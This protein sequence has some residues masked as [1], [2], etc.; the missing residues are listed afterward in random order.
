MRAFSG[1]VLLSLLRVSALAAAPPP[2]I[3]IVSESIDVRAVNVEAVVVDRKGVPVRGLQASDLR[4]L[5][6]GKEVP[7]DSLAEVADG[8]TAA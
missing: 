8:A 1:V 7:I 2:Q 6:D 3:P 4:L 5:V